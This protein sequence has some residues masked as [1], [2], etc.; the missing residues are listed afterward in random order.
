VLNGMDA[1]E[2]KMGGWSSPMMA[3]TD[4]NAVAR[5]VGGA[6]V[7]DITDSP[8]QGRGGRVR[9]DGRATRQLARIGIGRTALHAAQ[10]TACVGRAW[11]ALYGFLA[12]RGS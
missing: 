12:V 10:C 9:G 2:A 4:S 5:G 11:K 3:M 6:G 7:R 8:R 1:Q